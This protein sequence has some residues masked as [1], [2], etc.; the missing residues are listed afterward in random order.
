M[1]EG[2]TGDPAIKMRAFPGG[3]DGEGWGLGF[4][5]GGIVCLFLPSITLNFFFACR[6]MGKRR[7][8]GFLG[9]GRKPTDISIF[10]GA[11]VQS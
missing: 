1:Q 10:S 2:S 4:L 9:L 5:L 6:S 3:G 7:L 8:D 11:Y